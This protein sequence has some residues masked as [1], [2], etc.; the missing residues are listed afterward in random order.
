MKIVKKTKDVVQVPVSKT[1]F[2]RIKFGSKILEGILKL[3]GYQVFQGHVTIGNQEV[4]LGKV[5]L[6]IRDKLVIRPVSNK[7]DSDEGLQKPLQSTA[8]N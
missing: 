4:P 3:E 8:L 5:E 6:T 1:N 2:N 7:T